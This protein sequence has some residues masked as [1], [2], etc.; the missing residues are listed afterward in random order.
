MPRFTETV[1][2]QTQDLSTGAASGLETLSGKLEVFKQAA[3]R[4]VE[5]GKIKRGIESAKKVKLQKEQG[6]TQ[7]P[8]FKEPSIIGGVERKAHNKA[9]RSSYFASLNNDNRQFIEKFRAE[10]PDDLIGFNESSEAYRKAV[11]SSV[12][13][14]SRQLV[15]E[16]LDSKITS[17]R[18][19]VQTASIAKQ[20][21][22]AVAESVSN[23]NNAANAAARAARNGEDDVAQDAAK[24]ALI[25]IEA[26][27]ESGDLTR[28]QATDRA[29]EI[30]REVAE[31][32]IRKSLDDLPLDEA[33]DDIAKKSRKVP[34]GWKP[35]EWDAFM[36][37]ANADLN[38]KQA[39]VDRGLREQK[40]LKKLGDPVRGLLFTSPDI[41]A[42]P[43]KSGQ[44]RKD[45]NAAYK[46][47]AA[48]WQGLPVQEQIENNV[49]FIK[50]TGIVPDDVISSV[51]AAARSGSPDQVGLMVDLVSRIQELPNSAQALRDLP[52]ESRSFTIQVA[53]ATRAGTDIETAIEIARK[54]TYGLTAQLREKI[55]L[56]TQAVRKEM[57]GFLKA[58]VDEEF[59]PGIFFGDGRLFPGEPSVPVGMQADYNVAF[60]GFMT[61]TDGNTEQAKQLAFGSIKKVWSVTETGGDRRF[62]KFAPEAFYGVQGFDNDWIEDQFNEEMEIAGVPGATLSVDFNTGRSDTPSYPIMIINKDGL[63]DILRDETTGVPKRWRP[64]ITQTEQFKDMQAEQAGAIQS[65]KKRRAIKF[66]RRAQSL[67]RKVEAVVLRNVP[68]ETRKGFITTKEGKNLARI[69]INNM[70]V[71]DKIDVV[72]ASEMLKAFDAGD[73]ESL[74]VVQLRASKGGSR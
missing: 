64:D 16:D 15:S 46:Q 22:E 23:I 1:N 21:S 62:M 56:Q 55:K 28:A 61:L 58:Q 6:I 51:N 19:R 3:Q 33:F 30:G 59:D 11:L 50:N 49:S 70:L 72:E 47:Q 37:D 10:N 38:R 63:P 45:I 67:R 26:M 53:D 71:I 34:K 31:Q 14:V 42:D 4:K 20:R 9:L 54:N 8:E 48:E 24:D 35:D 2:I 40:A 44:D 73:F 68:R 5:A 43:A 66:G 36:A 18:I 74:P 13:P 41:P 29:R 52:D 7:A 25:T 57:P 32:S 12:D 27:V 39:R 17:A 69:T 65:A 60:D